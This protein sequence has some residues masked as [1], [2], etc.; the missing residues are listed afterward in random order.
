MRSAAWAM[1][2]EVLLLRVITVITNGESRGASPQAW[3]LE[4]LRQ[5]VHGIGLF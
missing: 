5:I 3:L 4:K 1:V 2:E